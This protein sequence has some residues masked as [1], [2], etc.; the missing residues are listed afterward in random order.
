[1]KVFCAGFAFSV[2]LIGGQYLFETT[3]KCA[4]LNAAATSVSDGERQREL[5]FYQQFNSL[6]NPFGNLSTVSKNSKSLGGIKE[7]VPRKYQPKSAKWKEQFTSTE[8]GRQQWNRYAESK[9]FSLILKV[10]EDRGE[11]AQTDQYI[12]DEQG[13]LVGATITLGSR[14]EKGFPDPVYYPVMNSLSP[15]RITVEIDGGLLAATKIAHEIGHVNQTSE[16]N[17]DFFELQSKLITEYIE[18]FLKNGH[19]SDDA[20]LV[21]MSQKMGGTPIKIWESREYWSEVNAMMF[22]SEKINKEN[23]Y[24]NVLSGVKDNVEEYA[25]DYEPRFSLAINNSCKK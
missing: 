23:F 18:V 3:G 24:C 7:D 10:S 13:K 9:D 1:M 2:L 20:K 25:K 16:T 15:R 12:W 5:N 4:P 8:F 21:A 22:L 17:K 6:N 14:I 19:K 11:G